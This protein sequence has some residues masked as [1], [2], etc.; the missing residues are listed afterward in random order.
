[1]PRK[2][3]LQPDDPDEYKRFIET[4]NAVEASDDPKDLERAFKAVVMPSGPHSRPSGKRR[5]T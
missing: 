4:A 5:G 1:M 3:K 2:P